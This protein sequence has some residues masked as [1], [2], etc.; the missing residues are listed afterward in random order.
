MQPLENIISAA[1]GSKLLPLTL[2]EKY[3]QHSHLCFGFD[4][5]SQLLLL[6]GKREE[7]GEKKIHPKSSLSS[8]TAMIGVVISH[9][10]IFSEKIT[11]RSSR[12]YLAMGFLDAES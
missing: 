10:Y 12:A 8:K 6:V 5:K 1:L 4:L 9:L 11:L 3:L 2:V 7:K